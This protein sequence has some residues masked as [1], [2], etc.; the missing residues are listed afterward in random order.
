L[1]NAASEIEATGMSLSIAPC[2]I[3]VVISVN[4]EGSRCRYGHTGGGNNGYYM[5]HGFW[6]T[7]HTRGFAAGKDPGDDGL[8]IPNPPGD[9]FIPLAGGTPPNFHYVMMSMTSATAAKMSV[10][11]GTEWSAKVAGAGWSSSE[12]GF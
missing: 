10:D 9:D 3:I 8:L 4:Q 11:G 1:S 2:S 7:G 6:G 12:V 5:H